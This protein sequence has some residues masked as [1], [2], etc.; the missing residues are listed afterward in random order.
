MK[1]AQYYLSLKNYI[2]NSKEI[3]LH[4]SFERAKKP[5]KSTNQQCNMNLTILIATEGEQQELSFFTGGNAKSYR[6]FGRLLSSF[7][8]N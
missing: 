6:H 1:H 4:T 2:L 7:L 3:L 5:N 8:Q